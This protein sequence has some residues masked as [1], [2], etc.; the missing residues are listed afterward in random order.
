MRVVVNDLGAELDGTGRSPTAADEVVAEIAERGGL[1]VASYDDIATPS[2]SEAAVATAVDQFGRLDAVVNNAGNLRD[3]TFGKVAV[4]DFDAV[5]RVHLLGAAY[6]TRAAW[7]ALR[8]SGSGRVV[9]TTSATGLYGQVGQANYGAAK[10][11]LIGLMNVLKHEGARY[12]VM[13]NAIAPVAWTRMT[14][15]LLPPAAEQGLRP[16]LV[17]PVV[18]YLTSADCDQT[19]LVLEVG[20]GLVARVSIVESE[21]VLL[22]PDLDDDGVVREAILSLLDADVGRRMEGVAEATARVVDAGLQTAR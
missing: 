21:P 7:P 12:G 6:C 19:G 16:S 2:G 17:T 20:G 11:G 1:A 5:I 18:A 9:F 3:R 14:R 8:E 22:G 15:D 10:A 4:E 13:V